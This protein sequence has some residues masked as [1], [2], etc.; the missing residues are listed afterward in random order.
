MTS[1]ENRTWKEYYNFKLEDG[2][3]DGMYL[4]AG[5]NY[6]T[7]KIP[8]NVEQEIDVERHDEPNVDVN[9]MVIPAT[10]DD[11]REETIVEDPP[12][13]LPEYFDDDYS[14]QESIFGNSNIEYLTNSFSSAIQEARHDAFAT[15]AEATLGGDTGRA[16]N[17]VQRLNL[18]LPLS[19]Q[20]V[21]NRVYTIPPGWRAQD[22]VYRSRVI[23][24]SLSVLQEA[25]G[26][27]PARASAWQR[28]IDRL[29]RFLR[30]ANPFR[31]RR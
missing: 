10:S 6:W 20:I 11:G 30:V 23:S 7:F 5:A 31:R 26:T 19:G 12:Q 18:E 22:P 2:T 4:H 24:A 13:V 21:H 17:L 1:N 14:D 25:E 3:E 15:Q 9:K 29:R 16:Y 8:D 28:R 27:E